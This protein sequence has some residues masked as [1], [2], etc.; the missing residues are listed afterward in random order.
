MPLWGRQWSRTRTTPAPVQNRSKTWRPR[1]PQ[2]RAWISCQPMSDWQSS[3]GY[4]ID[5][6]AYANKCINNR[7]QSQSHATDDRQKALTAD[8]TAQPRLPHPWSCQNLPKKP[9]SASPQVKTSTNTSL[10][11]LLR[12]WIT[13]SRLSRTSVLHFWTVPQGP[14]LEPP[15]KQSSNFGPL[16]TLRFW[17]CESKETPGFPGFISGSLYT[18]RQY[19]KSKIV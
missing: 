5:H 18:L 7:I 17:H 1:F 9:S 6:T 4:P 8:S 3:A 15:P 10:N 12:F 11:F 14:F 2:L 19:I 13:L 16:P